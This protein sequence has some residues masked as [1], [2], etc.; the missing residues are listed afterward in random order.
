MDNTINKAVAYSLLAHIKTSGILA[1]GPIDI[2]IPLV[3]KGLHFMNIHKGQYKGESI[4]EIRKIIEEQYSIDIPIPV[5]KSILK[6]IANDINK[7]EKIFELFKDNSFW[8]KD[9]VFEDF[10]EHIEKSKKEIIVLQDMFKKFCKIN[11]VEY[12]E[13]SCIIKFIE[14]NKVSISGYLANTKNTDGDDFTIAA[15]FVDYFR[16]FPQ[17]Y[18]QIRNLYL[19]S[20]L[21]CY[22]NYEPANVKM[23][24][25]LLLD[26]N[27]IISL[28][29]LNTEE[30][31]HTCNKLLEICLKIGY[32]CRILKD[33]LEETKALLMFKSSNYAKETITRYINKEDIYNAC[34]R[35]NLNSV[36]LD[37][38]SDNL[39]NDLLKKEV[40]VIP[41]TDKLRN[42]AKHSTEYSILKKY[43]NTEKAALHDAMALIYVKEE[44]GKRVKDF[45]KV[46]CWF[47]NNAI[48]HDIDNE[49]IDALLNTEQND[50]QPELIKADFLLN[51]LW[52]SKPNVSLE[53]AN[54]DLVDMGLTSL[55]AYTLNESL[56]K[57][58]IIKE[59]DENIQ[60]YK[61]TDFSDRDVLL[62][63]TRIANRQVQNIEG[64]NELAKK[65]SKQF[66]DR[67]KEEARKQDTI[68]KDRA[69]KF[70][71]LFKELN[72]KIQELDERSQNIEE[73]LS[74]QKDE[75]IK[76]I[77]EDSQKI[78]EEK[79]REISKLKK[80]KID[81]ENKKREEMLNVYINKKIK[82]WRRKSWIL[83]GICFI[84]FILLCII[85][86]ALVCD[87][88]FDKINTEIDVFF[89]NKVISIITSIIIS[90]F[91]A[92]INYFVIRSLY[93][94]YH[95]HS[96]INN[97]KGSIVIPDE[98]KLINE[99]EKTLN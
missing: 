34:E 24:V 62:L 42:K 56:P 66:S 14:K 99:L 89:Q 70:D 44:R 15:L 98:Y 39:E 36:D 9:Y 4:S 30:S 12:N 41:H 21:T 61:K 75:E 22:L 26:T 81:T 93:D 86:V 87:G 51:I 7:E 19:G 31:T 43:R 33:T 18:D 11:N 78:I 13:N 94:K 2:F 3:K 97:Y 96:N 40:I 63:A 58:R 76:Q 85:C 20:M 84:V 10:D 8:I 23:D 64:L 68:E 38:I 6:K 29:D 16:K 45:E 52:L 82:S 50:F 55:V 35:R 46:N 90:I 91:I 65:D 74:I 77:S 25:T 95:N 32:K 79:D 88:D 73:F 72:N 28:L 69:E 47:V 80:E 59:L 48:S 83:A 60:K 57:V 49:G 37:R 54:N 71:T 1:G 5:L 27:F 67:I 17:I 92:I 53:L